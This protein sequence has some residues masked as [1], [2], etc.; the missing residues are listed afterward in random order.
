MFPRA[1]IKR[2]NDQVNDTPAPGSY[3]VK[4]QSSKG[5]FGLII[6]N[7]TNTSKGIFGSTSIPN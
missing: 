1:A 3:D 4:D 2:F 5:I 6:N 7:F